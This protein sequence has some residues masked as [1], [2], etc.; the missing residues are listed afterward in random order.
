MKNPFQLF[1]KLFL[2]ITLLFSFNRMLKAQDVVDFTYS[3]SGSAV[4]FTNTSTGCYSPYDY[5]SHGW[6]FGD[7]Q[8]SVDWNPVHTYLTSGTFNCCFGAV[9]HPGGCGNAMVC[10]PINITVSGVNEF[11]TIN[12]SISNYPNPFSDV[13]TIS[14]VL[15]EAGSVEI[16]IYDELGNEVAIVES[17]NQ[18][19]AGQYDIPF[20]GSSLSQGIYFLRF[21][22]NGKSVM[23][24]M[25]ITR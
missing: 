21:T 8:S 3:V 1:A 23:E 12:G 22:L 6:T 14:Y 10:Y 20:D 24:K 18:Q 15:G 2:I 7:S 13:T 17:A 11:Q 9:N 19:G 4:T 5:P 16:S 25:A